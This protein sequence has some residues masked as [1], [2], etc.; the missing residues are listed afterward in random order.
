MT[1]MVLS[2]SDLVHLIKTAFGKP[3]PCVQILVDMHVS[4]LGSFCTTL[5]ND[6]NVERSS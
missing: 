3:V 1:Q 4:S 2:R 5:S 6:Q